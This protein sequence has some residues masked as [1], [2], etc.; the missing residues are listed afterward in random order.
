MQSN[1]FWGGATAR[2]QA[3]SLRLG[4]SII[5]PHTHAFPF[6]PTPAHGQA[7]ALE[8][9]EA[10]YYGN[11]AAAAMMLLLY[12]QVVEDCDRAIQLNP[13]NAK[14]YFRKGKALASMVRI[15]CVFVWAGGRELSASIRDETSVV[16][17]D[18]LRA[19]ACAHVPTCTICRAS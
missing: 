13:D 11:R 3:S 4:R 16:H 9:E 2:P 19:Q 10:A 12:D 18:R 6:T 5:L 1:V 17:L 8:P 7:I 15:E 14:M